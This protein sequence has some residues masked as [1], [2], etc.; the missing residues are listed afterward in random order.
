MKKLLKIA[1]YTSGSLLVF[2]LLLAGF[3]QTQMFRD[4]LRAAAL[5]SLDSLLDAEVHLGNL[6]GN[7]VTGFSIDHISIKVKNDYLLVAERLDLKY[8]L[9]EIPGKTISVAS[10][11]LIKPFVS[12]LRGR[13]GVWNF[14]RMI[15]PTPKDTS[16]HRPF[17]WPIV[18]NSLNISDGTIILVD[19][20]ALA[21]KDHPLPDP[22]YVEYHRV[23][24]REFNLVTSLMIRP[25]EK[26][27]TI[28]SL[29]F[30][31]EEPDVRLLQIS[32]DFTVTPQATTVKDMVLKTEKT[33]LQLDAQMKDIDLLGG[34]DVEQL[35]HNQVRLSL[36]AHDVDLNELKRFIP[37]IGFLNGTVALDLEAGGEFGE[38]GIKKLNMSSGSTA[39]DIKGTVFNLQTPRNLFLD[40]KM[41]N[42]RILPADP[43]TILPS[44]HLPE[45]PSLGVLT[46]NLEFVGKPLDFRTTF[47]IQTNAGELQSDIAL[48]IDGSRPLVYKGEVQ[49]H[50]LNIALLL[51]DENLTSRLNGTVHIDGQGT[52]IDDLVGSLRAD[53][54]SSEFLSQ[55]VGRSQIALD[56]VEK[57]IIASVDITMGGMHSVLNGEFGQQEVPSFKVDGRVTSFNFEDFTHDTLH[58]SDLT[59]SLNAHGAGHS[60]NTLNGDLALDFSPS[61]YGDYKITSGNVHLFLDQ[62]DLQQKQLKLESS[63]ADFSL[64]GAFDMEYLVELIRFELLNVRSAVVEKF[65][66]VDSSLGKAIDR[67][68][69][70]ALSVDLA[71]KRAALDVTYM[72]QLKDLEPISI[73]TGNRKFNGVGTI[74]GVIRGDQKNLSF[75]GKL[76]IADFFYGNVDGGVLIQDA[77][78]D[79]KM[80]NLKP[81]NLLND[82]GVQLVTSA[83]KVHINRTELD[84]LQMTV[85]YQQEYSNYSASATVDHDTRFAIKGRASVSQDEVLFTLNNFQLAF[86][87]FAWNAD[88]GATIG[89]NAQSAHVSSLVM[90]R[91]SQ[92]VIINGTLASHGELNATLVAEAVDLGCLRYLLSKEELD[93]RSQGF[94]GKAS[95]QINAGGTLRDPHYDCSLGAEDVM[96]RGVPF[97]QLQGDLRYKDRAL[98]IDAMV[99]N[100]S[101]VRTKEQ[102][103]PVLTITGTLPINL[104]L[105]EEPDTAISV[106]DMNIKTNHLQMSFLDP[107]LPT[108]NQLSGILRCDLKI[109]GLPGN[110]TYA[111]TMSI[112]SCSFLFVP[113]NIYYTFEGKFQPEGDHIKVLDA[114]VRNLPR[115]NT[116]DREGILH[117]VGDFRLNEFKPTD[118][119]LTT[120]GQLLVVKETT[121]KSSL[122]VYG[123]LFIEIGS[124]GLHYTGTIEQSQLQGSVL[125]RNSSLVFP[126]TKAAATQ[127]AQRTIPLIIIDDTSKVREV[128]THSATEEYFGSENDDSPKFT[129]AE[130]EDIPTK[131]FLDGVRYDLNIETA[132]GNTQIRMIFNT[133]TNEELVANVD[134]KFTIIGDGTQ[135]VGTVTVDKAY[136]YFFK[137]FDA[138]G[139]IRYTGDLLNPELNIKARYEGTRALQDS[140]A[141]KVE[142]VVVNLEITGTRNEPKL[143]ISMSI[144]DVD[145]YSYAGLKSSD[146][147]SDALAFIITGAF[148]LSRSQKNDIASDIGTTVGSSLFGGATSLFSSTLTEFLSRETGF[149]KAVELS[150][151]AQGSVGEGTDIRVTGTAFKGLW[152]YGGRILEDPFSN[153]NVSIL[154]SFGDIFTKPALR[155]FMFELERK[156]EI[157]TIGQSSE[158]KEINSARLFY[159]F[160]F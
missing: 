87:D 31:S 80:T 55:T 3:T 27:A 81:Q 98:S 147:Q 159:R 122:S 39:F 106:M 51:N 85:Q 158:R 146:V 75:E 56:A 99:S 72:L 13:D 34:I 67:K 23:I 69:L 155:N 65:V 77:T 107:L 153:A 132:G 6:D 62:H 100:P 131:S 57:K 128:H 117:L 10:M 104:S 44:L 145:Y 63:L 16:T 120:T 148:P 91:D 140:S 151:R 150:Y 12:L 45:F 15:R 37:Q 61:R 112:D 93:S 123:N 113:N 130:K 84:S 2:L 101:H 86:K 126:P 17:D 114:S 26:H 134:G 97:G 54:D 59:L 46:L 52:S 22:Y 88:G 49:M 21:S 50:N 48:K 118:F 109:K 30:S 137:R 125:I 149:I 53:V 139:T 92:S 40:V 144:D 110:P 152:R 71:A 156:V 20:S 43:L 74:Q 141:E 5:S 38:L 129:R 119:N 42:S 90:R 9:F 102:I 25:G 33:N 78:A 83:A 116:G 136:Y 11:T 66:A 79:L 47:S 124:Q 127:E 96:F 14:T 7:L 1:A 64:T 29:S 121:R 58:N 105:A 82:L 103:A 32:G 154:Y 60:L 95:I 8:D 18:V 70:D 143:N 35:Q 142:K 73:V 160:S 94:G 68:Q 157:G 28:K 115:D 133:A 89:F 4:R 41:M 138:E 111:G 24:L 19:S 36:H 108:F 76:A 135:W